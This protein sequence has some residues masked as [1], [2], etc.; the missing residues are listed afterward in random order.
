MRERRGAL[1]LLGVASA[2]G[3]GGGEERSGVDGGKGGVESRCSSISSKTLSSKLGGRD[4]FLSLRRSRCIGGL[5]GSIDNEGPDALGLSARWDVDIYPTEFR[6]LV[7]GIEKTETLGDRGNG[8][9]VL[10]NPCGSAG[11]GG[12]GDDLRYKRERLLVVTVLSSSL[13][14][15]PN[16][17]SSSDEST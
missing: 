16:S 10:C 9:T 15:K 13:S 1:L 14:P 6:P 2:A 8:S 3:G 7:V 12:G 4:F 5:G 17:P 11:T